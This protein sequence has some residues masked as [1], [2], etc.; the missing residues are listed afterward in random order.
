MNTA[1]LRLLAIW[2][3]LC[4]VIAV[5]AEAQSTQRLPRRVTI[6]HN[7]VSNGCP[8]PTLDIHDRR[9]HTRLG[10]QPC[11]D[12]LKSIPPVA[13]IFELQPLLKQYADAVA[14][15]S[16]SRLKEIWLEDGDAPDL[17]ATSK[18]CGVSA[19]QGLLQK[20][21]EGILPLIAPSG[22]VPVAFSVRSIVPAVVAE[23]TYIKE[24]AD[25]VVVS[26]GNPEQGW[27]VDADQGLNC[28]HSINVR[29]EVEWSIVQR[30]GRWRIADMRL[31]GPSR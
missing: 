24:G 11:K 1:T 7:G 26:T 27:L 10:E 15:G 25:Y 6:T 12:L 5:A 21:R 18:S 20:M 8:N 22:R 4:G 17:D 19:P 14:D 30:N 2:M 28:R 31:V 13:N 3:F 29:T 16:T 23:L 9:F